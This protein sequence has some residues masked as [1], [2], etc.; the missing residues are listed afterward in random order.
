MIKGYVKKALIVA[1]LSILKSVWRDEMHYRIPR[2]TPVVVHGTAAEREYLLKSKWWNVAI[3]NYS[4]IASVKHL[5]R[6]INFD[7]I[8]LDELATYRNHTT[9]QWRNTYELVR[10]AP[11]AVG[12]TGSPTPNGPWDIYGQVNMFQ[13][14]KLKSMSSREF[15]QHVA[16]EV[17]PGIWTPRKN[18]AA[19]VYN[20]MQPAIRFLRSDV[21]ELKGSTT[22]TLKVD[23]SKAQ[24]E[25]IDEL[26]RDA[27]AMFAEGIVEAVNAAVLVGKILQGSAG[28]VY[29]T[30]KQVV[31]L[32]NTHR[33]DTAKELVSQSRNKVL[34][35]ASYVHLV[36]LLDRN[37]ED[38]PHAVVHGGTPQADRYRAFKSIQ[39]PN[40]PVR[41]LI[42]HPKCL[43]HGVNLT[44]ANV[45]IWYGP[46]TSYEIYQQANGRITRA[47]QKHEQLI[48]HLQGSPTEA[49]IYRTLRDHGN[50]Q[51]TILDLFATGDI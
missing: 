47:G 22:H 40:D 13:P 6:E 15:K 30:G 29:T 7:Y 10:R 51:A 1:P 23:L 39:D 35:F 44:G 20:L 14:E 43:A 4:G 38:V 3:I 2:L 16:E 49:R 17:K 9:Q 33:I 18:A 36:N 19:V 45:I 12:L 41:L 28:A 24:Q 32:K 48:Y 8:V 46:I 37:F 42:A 26:R 34:L 25:F 50:M 5:L 11:F 27:V 31:D 21:I